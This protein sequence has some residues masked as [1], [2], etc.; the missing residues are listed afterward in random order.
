MSHPKK[1]SRVLFVVSEMAILEYNGGSRRG[2]PVGP[3]ELAGDL[4]N[5]RSRHDNVWHN[6]A[7]AKELDSKSGVIG[8]SGSPLGYP[9]IWGRSRYLKAIKPTV[10]ELQYLLEVVVLRTAVQYRDHSIS[11]FAQTIER[12][13]GQQL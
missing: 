10:V 6:R 8:G 12:L 1:T 11:D 4:R 2:Q 9:V 5:R 3:R 7:A 13:H